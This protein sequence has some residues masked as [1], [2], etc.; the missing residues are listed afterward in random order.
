LDRSTVFDRFSDQGFIKTV[1]RPGVD[2]AQ[3]VVLNRR[4]NELLNKGNIEGAKRIFLTTGYS[5]GLIR[6][7]DQYLSQGKSMEALRMYWLAPDRKKAEEIIS[8][9]SVLIQKLLQEEE[10]N[11]D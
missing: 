8:R 9:L 11:H 7:G 6:V 5:D 2:S 10:S 1:A 4:G 3:K